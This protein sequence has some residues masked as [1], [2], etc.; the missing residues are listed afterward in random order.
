MAPRRSRPLGMQSSAALCLPS[1]HCGA[2]PT[3]GCSPPSRTRSAVGHGAKMLGRS[4]AQP[5]AVSRTA[6]RGQRNRSGSCLLPWCGPRRFSGAGALGSFST[7]KPRPSRVSSFWARR[8]RSCRVANVSPS[9]PRVA[10]AR[11]AAVTAHR[12]PGCWTGRH[13]QH[14]PA[15]VMAMPRGRRASWCALRTW[16]CSR[17]R[18]PTSSRW[19]AGSRGNATNASAIYLWST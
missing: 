4:P 16:A 10:R 7:S 11:C 6:A 8:L 5:G 19:Q 1:P 2:T 17:A 15:S 3:A 13:G 12:A 18:S 9:T 14:Q